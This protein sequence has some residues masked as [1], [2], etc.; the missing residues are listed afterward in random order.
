MTKQRFYTSSEAAEVAELSY[1]QVHRWTLKGFV[2]PAVPAAGSGSTRLFDAAGVREL[3]RLK[4]AIEA[5]PYPHKHAEAGLL[6]AVA[7]R[8]RAT[9]RAAS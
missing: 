9:Q 5:C 8:N 2:T 6:S 3:R 7:R 4:K 1:L